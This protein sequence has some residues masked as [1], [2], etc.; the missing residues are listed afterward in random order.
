[1]NSRERVIA[2]ISHKQS[3]KIPIDLGSTPSTGISAIAY[4]RL[5]QCIGMNNGNTRVYD[6]IQQLALPEKEIIEYFGIDVIDV[7]RLFNTRD[8]DWYDFTLPNGISVQYPNW[9]RPVRTS[10]GSL[11][12]FHPDGTKIAKMS[13]NGFAFDQIVFPYQDGYP[14]DYLNLSNDMEKVA[15]SIRSQEEKDYWKNLQENTAFLRDTTDKALIVGSG[16]K[17]FEWGTYLR[18]ID[19]LLTDFIRDRRNVKRLFDAIFMKQMEHLKKICKSIGNLVNIIRFTD[20]LGENNGPF[21]S[22]KIYREFIK[23]YHTEWCEYVHKNTSAFTFLHCCG[24]ILPLI[25]DL[26]DAGFDILNPVQIN[27]KNMNPKQLKEEFGDEIT[28]WGGGADSRHVLTR[29]KPEE[30]KKHVKELLE[31]FFAGGGYVWNTVH[32]IL[33]DVPPENI[34]AMFNAV[35]EFNEEK[36]GYLNEVH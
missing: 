27:A 34:I 4:S 3:D 24:S 15:W 35:K 28:F 11:E 36:K 30:I 10:Q 25:P 7:S 12:L 31:I 29:K 17:L 19:K 8:R 14:K 22:P 33:P 23:P 1:L 20:D 16:C 2:A 5:K 21:M 9:F 6:V 18:R 26:I 13:K 32:N